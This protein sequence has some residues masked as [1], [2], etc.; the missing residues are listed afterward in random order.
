MRVHQLRFSNESLA[1][2]VCVERVWGC[3]HVEVLSFHLDA[4][5]GIGV[6]EVADRDDDLLAVAEHDDGRLAVVAAGVGD[7]LGARGDELA[8]VLVGEVL[9]GVALLA[10]L[11]VHL[12][13][14][15]LCPAPSGLSL[16]SED[17]VPVVVLVTAVAEIVAE[18][19]EGVFTSLPVHRAVAAF[20]FALHQAQLRI[21]GF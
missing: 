14:R 9:G 2:H 21:A 13:E 16:V 4:Q 6:G 11:A 7:G 1:N 20:A 15:I 10:R 3:C 17:E 5:A 8:E 12:D 19:E 18:Q